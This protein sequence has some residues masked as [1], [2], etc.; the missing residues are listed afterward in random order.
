MALWGG[1]PLFTRTVPILSSFGSLRVEVRA[2]LSG[3]KFIF[4]SRYAIGW[5]QKIAFSSGNAQFLIKCISTAVQ[6]AT[7]EAVDISRF[8]LVDR[9]IYYLSPD[10]RYTR[11]IPSQFLNST[12]YLKVEN[13][14]C[15]PYNVV[16]LHLVT[17]AGPYI[18][19]VY[20]TAEM[21]L[22]LTNALAEAIQEIE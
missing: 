16:V 4:I 14:H 13:N 11:V 20:F 2:D 7:T 5:A 21:A 8:D 18:P 19:K 15:R 10:V 9:I 22:S 12:I 3:N 17:G 6:I 1:E